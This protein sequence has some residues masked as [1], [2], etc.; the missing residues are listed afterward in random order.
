[1]KL[2]AT[3]FFCELERDRNIFKVAVRMLPQGASAA[4]AVSRHDP[5]REKANPE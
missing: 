5:F 2:Y 3:A 1:M 4:D